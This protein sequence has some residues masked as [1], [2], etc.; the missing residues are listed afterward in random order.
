MLR[1]S[2]FSWP[3]QIPE[4]VVGQ[5]RVSYLEQDTQPISLADLGHPCDLESQRLTASTSP[6]PPS[7]VPTLGM[8]G[9]RRPSRSSEGGAEE[10]AQGEAT[11]GDNGAHKACPTGLDYS[12]HLESCVQGLLKEARD[13]FRGWV[14]CSSIEPSIDLAYKK[15]C[16]I[17][18]A[19]VPIR[20][21]LRDGFK[22]LFSGEITSDS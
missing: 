1:I 3:A 17:C 22:F 11:E 2:A 18:L 9:A 12:A 7:P 14:N 21:T 5:C 15:V 20:Q 13:R 4:E 19:N 8:P 10:Y 6:F 16:P